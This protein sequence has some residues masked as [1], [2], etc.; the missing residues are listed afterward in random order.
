MSKQYEVG[1]MQQEVLLTAYSLLKLSDSKETTPPG[2]GS[3][4]STHRAEKF[5]SKTLID[6]R[7]QTRTSKT[8]P[9]GPVQIEPL[10]SYPH[11][12]KWKKFEFL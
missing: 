1:S 2:P 8:C 11:K 6:A 10:I 5:L 12:H 9:H 3:K 7:N 4:T